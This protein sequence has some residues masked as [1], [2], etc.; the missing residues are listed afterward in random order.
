MSRYSLKPL[1]NRADVFEVAVGW[2]PGLSTY[3]AI[4]FGAPEFACEPEVLLWR[5]CT[6][7][8][9]CRVAELLDIVREFAEV[10]PEL[11]RRLDADPSAEPPS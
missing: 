3:F 10:A 9:I 1:P 2:D 4:V 6:F 8:E 5:G 11:R 7:G